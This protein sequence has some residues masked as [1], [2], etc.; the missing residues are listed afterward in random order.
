MFVFFINLTYK[1]L[2][3]THHCFM[4]INF[5]TKYI[6]FTQDGSKFDFQTACVGM[7]CYEEQKL[8][9]NWRLETRS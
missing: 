7:L 3:T 2:R 6:F 4:K 8:Q 5:E 1:S 9:I